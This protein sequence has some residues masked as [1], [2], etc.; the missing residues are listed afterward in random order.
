MRFVADL[1]RV[2]PELLPDLQSGDLLLV[3]GAGSISTL[4]PR[5]V[6]ALEASGR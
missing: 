4:G 3:M 2:V 5:L 6:A 1:D